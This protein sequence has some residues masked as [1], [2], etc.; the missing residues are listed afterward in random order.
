MDELL[1]NR[2]TIQARTASTNDF[3]EKTYSYADTYTNIHC[4]LAHVKGA[5]IRL[6]SGEF[7]TST[8]VLF[9]KSTQTID[10]TYRVVGTTGFSGTYSVTKVKNIYD[11]SALH[12]IEVELKK[13]V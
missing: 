8:P 7:V 2:C 3:G 10:E 13:V 4:R 12:H 5:M 1:V 9:L 6:D 11:S